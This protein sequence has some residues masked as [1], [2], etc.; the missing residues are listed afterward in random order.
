MFSENHFEIVD[1]IAEE[2]L[3]ASH[4]ILPCTHRKANFQGVPPTGKHFLTPTVSI[5]LIK[6]GKIVERRIYSD[7]LGMMQQFGLNP[8]SQATK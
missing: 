1:Q 3:V 2:D 7:R 6:D 5:E 8:P 4:V